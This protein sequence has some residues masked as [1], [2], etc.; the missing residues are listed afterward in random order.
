M[1]RASDADRLEIFQNVVEGLHYIRVEIPLDNVAK[2]P[3]RDSITI[4]KIANSGY[5][6][7]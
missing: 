6:L 4:F 3:H 5:L 2:A 1:W 7:R